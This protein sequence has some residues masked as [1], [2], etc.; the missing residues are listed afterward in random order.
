MILFTS[1]ANIQDQNTGNKQMLPITVTEVQACT[2]GW[3]FVLNGDRNGSISPRFTRLLC[4][5]DLLFSLRGELTSS[6]RDSKVNTYRNCKILH[7]L[8]GRKTRSECVVHL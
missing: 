8:E 4:M 3:L 7:V 1:V 6:N 5:F 2:S